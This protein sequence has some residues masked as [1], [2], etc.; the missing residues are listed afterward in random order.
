MRVRNTESSATR[1]FPWP[2]PNCVTLTVE[3]TVID[4]VAKVKQDGIVYELRLPGIEVP[5]CL[6]CGETII[7][8]EVDEKINDELRTHL[9]LLKPA[10]LREHIKKLNL[11][12]QELA[13]LIGVAPETISRWLN[14][15][16]IQSRAMDN[17]LR[18]YFDSEEVRTLLK[19]QFKPELPAPA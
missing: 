9:H 19:Q 13:E 2:C 11:K 4:H 3:P 16:L 8:T 5:R 14:G 10:Q 12:Q 7:T 1:P 17:L 15:A 18:L 6:T